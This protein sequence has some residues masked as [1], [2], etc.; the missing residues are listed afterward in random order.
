MTE[1]AIPERKT[2]YEYLGPHLIDALVDR[3]YDRVSKDE[4]LAPFFAHMDLARLRIR[5]KEFLTFVTGG[6]SRYR[7]ADLRTAHTMPVSM[8]MRDEHFEMV[9]AVLVAE[10]KDFGVAEDRIAELGVLVESVRRDVLNR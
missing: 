1:S 3:L 8:G 4:R 5:M 7:G 6:P 2:L 10:L 9:V